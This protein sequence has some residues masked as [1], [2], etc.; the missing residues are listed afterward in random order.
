MKR[1]VQFVCV[2]IVALAAAIQTLKNMATRG[3]E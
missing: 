2:G 1:T 3:N